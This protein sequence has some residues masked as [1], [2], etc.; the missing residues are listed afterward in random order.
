MKNIHKIFI[1]LIFVFSSALLSGQSL[2]ISAGGGLTGYFI[3]TINF[4]SST[5]SSDARVYRSDSVNLL[6]G[7]AVSAPVSVVYYLK[8]NVGIGGLAELGY[9]FLGGPHVYLSDAVPGYVPTQYWH[10][11]HS[12]VGIFNLVI[13]SPPINTFRFL[14]E[15]GLIIRPGVVFNYHYYNNILFDHGY[16]FLFYA[17]PNLFLGFHK[18]IM[19]NLIITP[20]LRISTEFAGF[21]LNYP[22]S[23]HRTFYML[24]NFG[25]EFRILYRKVIGLGQNKSNNYQAPDGNNSNKQNTTPKKK[26]KL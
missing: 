5:I 19:Q 6:F 14:A 10:T 11:L 1:L 2:E 25:L 9:S 20:G 13:K 8:N 3:P 16:R 26:R 17:G 12:F 18:T 15:F 4:V 23:Y 24:A 22:H 7:L 21:Q